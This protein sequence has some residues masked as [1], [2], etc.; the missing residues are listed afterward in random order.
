MAFKKLKTD[1]D[2]DDDDD[3]DDDRDIVPHMCI[4]VI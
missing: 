2:D 1:Y 3:D 4:L